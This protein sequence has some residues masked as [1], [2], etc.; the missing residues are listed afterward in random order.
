MVPSDSG[1]QDFLRPV[2][3]WQSPPSFSASSR[4][5]PVTAQILSKIYPL[6]FLKALA[7]LLVISAL[8]CVN[9]PLPTS[10]AVHRFR[11][12]PSKVSSNTCQTKF[13][14]HSLRL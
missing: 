2:S 3:A 8:T 13:F 11:R 14:M 7:Y 10:T 1:V 5:R 12:H 6:P 9:N 4:L